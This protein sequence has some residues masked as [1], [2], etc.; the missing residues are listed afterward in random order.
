MVHLNWRPIFQCPDCSPL[1]DAVCELVCTL[2]PITSLLK[3]TKRHWPYYWFQRDATR[4]QLLK[5]FCPQWSNQFTC[6][7]LFIY[8][9]NLDLKKSM[10]GSLSEI[11]VKTSSVQSQFV[12][13]VILS[14][15]AIERVLDG[16]EN[17]CWLLPMTLFFMSLST[18][19]MKERVG[20]IKWSSYASWICTVETTSKRASY[21]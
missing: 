5:T 17:P 12:E 16:S 8:L 21:L 13:L 1:F 2:F 18:K 19:N 3:I 4:N 7:L 6:S 14:H 15:K 10:G 20:D 9:I 11:K